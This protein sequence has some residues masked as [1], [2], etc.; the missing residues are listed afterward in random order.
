[1]AARRSR[2]EDSAS[3][4][5]PGEMLTAQLLALLKGWSGYGYELAQRLEQSGWPGLNHGTLYRTL[6]QM[7]RMGL[8]SSMWDTSAEGPARRV[9]NLTAAGSL[10]LENWIALLEAHRDILGIFLRRTEP[11]E[12]SPEPRP[13]EPRPAG[14]R[15]AEARPGRRASRAGGRARSSSRR[16]RGSPDE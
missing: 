14:A 16:A 10:F 15:P 7:E 8:V 12:G 13:P 1:M 4:K 6:R 3:P 9:Y 2:E 5:A 11:R